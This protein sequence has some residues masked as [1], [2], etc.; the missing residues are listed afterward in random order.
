MKRISRPSEK[1]ETLNTTTLFD[2]IMLDELFIPILCQLGPCELAML[3]RVSRD[4]RERATRILPSIGQNLLFEY[5]IGSSPY[6]LENENLITD[7]LVHYH[8]AA[9]AYTALPSDKQPPIEVLLSLWHTI[10]TTERKT[11]MATLHDTRDKCYTKYAFAYERATRRITPL[12]KLE[13]FEI[14]FTDASTILLSRIDEVV[15]PRETYFAKGGKLTRFN[16]RDYMV[17]YCNP[18]LMLAPG[19]GG[20]RGRLLVHNNGDILHHREVTHQKESL[21]HN[22]APFFDHYAQRCHIER[23]GTNGKHMISSMKHFEQVLSLLTSVSK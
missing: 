11:T 4:T 3:V 15:A 2:V 5:V 21:P 6:A 19:Q 16:K 17:F 1:I 18:F 14:A 23:K 13:L 22:K 8:T 9:L 7:K 10:M 20:E 12:D